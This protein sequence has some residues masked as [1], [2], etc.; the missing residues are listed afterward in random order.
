MS[1]SHPATRALVVG[2][3]VSKHRANLD[4][5]ERAVDHWARTG[6]AFPDDPTAEEIA[7]MAE[8]IMGTV[9]HWTER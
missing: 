7:D 4:A 5:S 2:V 6:G 8:D 3:L 9:H 1:A